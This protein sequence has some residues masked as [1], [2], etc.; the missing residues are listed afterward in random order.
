MRRALAGRADSGDKGELMGGWIVGRRRGGWR[1]RAVLLVALTLA[2]LVPAGAAQAMSVFSPTG[3]W[4]A[5]IGTSPTI[6]PNSGPI[7]S[8]MSNTIATKMS[9]SPAKYP[10]ISTTQYSTPVYVV[11]P[12]T[13]KRPIKMDST[14]TALSNA[15]VADHGVPFPAGAQPADGT[16]G[17]IVVY[18]QTSQKM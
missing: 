1:A 10:N 13:P 12:G 16:D 8:Q 2:M 11:G 4:N 9:G 6:D 3:P 18:D 14:N 17:H 15:I 7:V 5:P